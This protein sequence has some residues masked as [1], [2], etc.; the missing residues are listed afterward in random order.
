MSKVFP[1][2]K[3]M[4]EGKVEG[5][6]KTTQFTVDA[7]M[8]EFEEGF[9]CRPIDQEHVD[10]FKETKRNGGTWPDIVV[11]VDNGRIICVEGHHRVTAQCQLLDEDTTG[12]VQP[13]LGASQFRGSDADCILLM[14]TSQ[15]GKIA[16]PLQ[17]GVQYRKLIAL[18]SSPKM[19]AAR[20]GKSAQHV[21]DMI[22]LAESNTDVQDMVTSG[23]VA[24]H[25]AL[26]TVKKHGTK[27]GKVLGD[28]LAKAKAEGKTKVT[29]KTVNGVSLVEAIKREM[30]SN[31]AILA[32]SLCPEH[33]ELIT[34]LRASGLK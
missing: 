33:I 23:K 16:T 32:E 21:K 26:S 17:L 30:Q 31:A 19:I 13:G 20:I 10:S 3:G 22:A 7:R 28:H 15:N 6:S 14:L 29:N 24:A 34:Y 4:A 2:L 12:T 1:S 27:A 18:G 25:V 9:N 8:V 5:V 11:R